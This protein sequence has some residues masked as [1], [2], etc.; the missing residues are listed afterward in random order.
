MG[1]FQ[2]SN[3]ICPRNQ[4]CSEWAEKNMKYCLCSAK[5]GVSLTLGIISVVSWGVAE[6]PQIVTNYREKSSEGLSVAFLLTWIL[7]YFLFSF[8]LIFGLLWLLLHFSNVASLNELIVLLKVKTPN[9]NNISYL[10]V[11]FIGILFDFSV[12]GC[13]QIEVVSSV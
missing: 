2:T 3:P 7:G 11:F 1:L 9:L 13:Y 5:D 4:H 12:I 8:S 6:I 10:S